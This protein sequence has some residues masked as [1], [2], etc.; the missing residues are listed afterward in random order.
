MSGPGTDIDPVLAAVLGKRMRAITEEMA[1]GVRRSSRSSGLSEA[2]DFVTGLFDAKGDM[3]EQIDCIPVISFS[4]PPALKGIIAQY[5]DDLAPGDVILHNDVFSGANQMADLAVY[6]PVF[7]AGELVAWAVTKGHMA[8]IGGGVAGAYNPRA[9]EVLQEALRVPPVKLYERGTLRRDVWDLVFANVRFAIVA[10]DV[11]ALV[12]GARLGERKLVEVLERYGVETFRAAMT[13]L[14][15]ATEARVRSELR[16]FPDGTYG[17]ESWLVNDGFDAAARHLI[18]VDVR[19]ADGEIEFDFSRSG[20]QAPGYTNAPRTVASCM[21]LTAVLMMIDPDIPHNAGLYRPFG[22]R[23]EPGSI[24]DP[25]PPAATGFGNHIGDLIFEAIMA[26]LGEVVADRATAGWNRHLTCIWTGEDPRTEQ[27]FV[28]LGY[29]IAR[30]GAGAAADV[31]GWDHLG[32]VF[33][34][35][36]VT[37]D[38]EVLELQTPFTML[39]YEFL[40]DSAGPGRRRGGLGVETVFRFDAPTSCS[41]L[42]D[43]LESEEAPAPRGLFGGMQGTGNTLT[44]TFPDGREYAPGSK[45]LVDVPSGTIWHQRQGGGGG[46]GSPAERSAELVAGEVR[47]GLLSTERAARIYN[48]V[49]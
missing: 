33:N 31:D 20:A 17:G 10:D 42:G 30:G 28:E 11:H 19:I 18:A 21:A 41:I 46:F 39:K 3:L 36:M 6:R 47:D 23:F 2:A 1:I 37:Q 38:L 5:G 24:V 13:Y 35:M 22:F 45:E 27:P 32:L 7:F 16:S 44:L 8:D 14:A 25:E 49:Q 48:H 43:G 34:P 26:A 40:P 12:G 9:R 29:M 15:D 4:I